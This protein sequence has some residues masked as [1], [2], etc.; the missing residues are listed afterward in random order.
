MSPEQAIEY[1]LAEEETGG[2]VTPEPSSY[3]AGLSAREAEVLKLVARGLTNAHIA[4]ELFISPRTV[5]RH[6]NSVYRKAGVGSRV[7]AA[8]FALEHNLL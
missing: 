7:A 4:R 8:R 3:P 6:L 5:D 2:T 1:A